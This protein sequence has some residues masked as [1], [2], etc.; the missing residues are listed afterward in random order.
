M[1][2][3]KG[4]NL[5]NLLLIA[6]FLPTIL[7]MK[8]FWLAWPL[9]MIGS[10]IATTAFVHHYPKLIAYRSI[11]FEAQLIGV[12][13]GLVILYS[14]SS[15]VKFGCVFIWFMWMFFRVIIT[16]S[17]ALFKYLSN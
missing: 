6:V 8:Q 1:A 15:N 12:L 5:I 16:K 2:N 17:A 3:R 10:L 4:V 11:Y 14:P 9:A 13:L 7:A